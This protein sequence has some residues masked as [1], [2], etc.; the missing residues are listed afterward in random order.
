VLFSSALCN[1]LIPESREYPACLAL[2]PVYTPRGNSRERIRR[3][4]RGIGRT[5]V[6]RKTVPVSP[7]F[8]FAPGTR[9]RLVFPWKIEKT[10]GRERISHA[11]PALLIFTRG[12]P[13]V[14]G[15]TGERRLRADQ[16]QSRQSRLPASRV[17]RVTSHPAVAITMY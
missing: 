11:G 10:R 1:E 13:L 9:A 12:S 5:P 3:I 4:A 15:Q 2:I 14:C 8:R 17:R 16:P 7:R 6:S